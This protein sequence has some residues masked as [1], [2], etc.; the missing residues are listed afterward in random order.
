MW[1]SSMLGVSFE[2]NYLEQL[3]ANFQKS[4]CPKRSK[5]NSLQCIIDAINEML[6]LKFSKIFLKHRASFRNC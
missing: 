3:H 4:K 5:L 6:E 2:K 1:N